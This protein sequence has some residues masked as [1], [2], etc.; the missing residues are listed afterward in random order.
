[1]TRIKLIVRGAKASAE[2]NGVLTSGMVG[3]PVTIEYDDSWDGLSK[4]LVCRGG[5]GYENF[6]GITKSVIGVDT[7]AKVAPEVMIAGKVLY[8][9]IEGYN[10]DGT[11]VIPTVWACCGTIRE[12]ANTEGGA[13]EDP[14]LPIWAQLQTQID[15]VPETIRAAIEEA[16]RNG[17]FGTGNGNGI[18]AAVLNAD[19]TLTLTFDDGTSYTTPSIRGAAGEKGEKGSK[20]DKGD[21]GPKGADGDDYVLTDADKTAIAELASQMVEVPEGGSGTRGPGILQV[22]TS[23]TSYTTAIGGQTPTKRMKL[24][25]IMSEASVSEVLV[26]DAIRHSYYL[27]PIYYVD[28]TYAYTK[29][30]TSIRGASGAKGSTGET[31]ATGAAGADGKDGVDGKTPVLGTDYFTEADREDM[32]QQILSELGAIP[33]YG[34]VDANNNIILTAALGDGTYTLKYENADGTV[35]EIGTVTVSENDAGG[36]ETLPAS[37]YA[38]MTWYDGVKLDKN[39]G[40]EGTGTGYC[41]SSHVEIWDGYTYTAKQTMYDGSRYGGVNVVYYDANGSLVSCTEL[42]VSDSNE[43]SVVLTPPANAVTFR[44]RVYYGTVYKPGMWPVYFE[45][46]A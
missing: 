31:G 28:D 5:L 38:E 15:E 4:N 22:S 45:K 21:T 40:S 8:L 32:I 35:T 29:S 20:G 23:P 13:S 26:G 41:A 11:T 44:L 10:K 3:V 18:Q 25:T 1:M 7:T 37:G 27:Y 9:G 46:T 19:Y 12:G 24:D 14:T 39:N 17:E 42:W 6:E 16:V 43:H 33:V 34:R 30:G 36:G 2:V